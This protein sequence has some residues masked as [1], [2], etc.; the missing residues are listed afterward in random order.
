[1][2]TSFPKSNDEEEDSRH[3]DDEGDPA[4]DQPEL[5]STIDLDEENGVRTELYNHPGVKKAMKTLRARM[6]TNVN[7]MP[8]EK[9]E[10]TTTTRSTDGPQAEAAK[11]NQGFI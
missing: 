4:D 9:P 3:T 6:R 1:M 11:Q 10:I 8:I 5:F 7:R 2:Q